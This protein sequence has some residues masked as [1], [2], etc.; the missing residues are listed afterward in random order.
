M[1]IQT[2]IGLFEELRAN[3][4]NEG[5]KPGRLVEPLRDVIG[6]LTRYNDTTEGAR[7]ERKSLVIMSLKNLIKECG[8]T[9]PENENIE[10]LVEEA[11]VLF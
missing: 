1:D 11:L 2:V 7:E 6:F 8:G 4:P 5:D 9:V 10:R 3:V